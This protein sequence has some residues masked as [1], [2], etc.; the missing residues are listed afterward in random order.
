MVHS[1]GAPLPLSGLFGLAAGLVV[2]DWPGGVY[3]GSWLPIQRSRAGPLSTLTMAAYPV[4]GPA[5]KPPWCSASESSVRL[6][7]AG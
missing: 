6:A 7:P 4:C 3:S 5:W 1:N 2:A